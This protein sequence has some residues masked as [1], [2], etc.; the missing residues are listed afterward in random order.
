MDNYMDLY[1]HMTN[2][3]IMQWNEF[4][5]ESSRIYTNFMTNMLS[6]WKQYQEITNMMF[7]KEIQKTINNTIIYS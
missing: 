5:H 7:M 2:M 6:N 4:I 3:T 1:K